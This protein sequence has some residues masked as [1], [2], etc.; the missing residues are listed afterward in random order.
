MVRK[1]KSIVLDMLAEKGY[2][3]A[4]VTP[5]IKPLPGGPKL[6][7]LTFHINEGPQVKIRLRR[8]RRQQGDHRRRRSS[9]R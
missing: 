8:L 7:N 6:V 4:T 2:Q 5:E 9:T 1:V 3:F